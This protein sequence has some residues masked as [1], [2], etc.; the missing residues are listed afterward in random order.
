[1]KI[2]I[3][4]DLHCGSYFGITPPSHQVHDYSKIQKEAWDE[5]ARVVKKWVSP[6][7]LIVNGDCIE[8]RQEKQGGAEVIT[9][10]RNVQSDMA[11]EA[12]NKWQAKKVYMTYGTCY[13]TGAGE[14][15]EYTIAQKIGA[16]IEGRLYLNI[17]GIVFD[18]RHQIGGSSIFHGRGTALL[19]QVMWDLIEESTGG[20]KVDV[21]VR[22]HVHWHIWVEMADK[23]AFITPGLQLRRG[24]FGSRQCSGPIDWGM[25]RLTIKEGKICEKEKEIVR[26]SANSP[27]VLRA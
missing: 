14:D 26:L 9:T 11:V 12:I 22:S 20:P 1:M 4:S 21:I 16:R 18:I 8:G 19:R 3:I 27:K 23:I 7:I 17:Q 6:D 25:I 13:H 2:V 5:Y 15:F 10:D 24:R